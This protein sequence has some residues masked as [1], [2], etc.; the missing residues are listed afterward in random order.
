MMSVVDSTLVKAKL[1]DKEGIQKEY[2][3]QKQERQ[4]QED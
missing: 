3:W 2:P 4:S 1:T